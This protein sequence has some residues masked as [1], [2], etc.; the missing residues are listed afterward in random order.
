MLVRDGAILLLTQAE[1]DH[2]DLERQVLPVSGGRSV[3]KEG[4]LGTG[5]ANERRV[6][7]ETYE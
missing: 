3:S 2:L 1:L 6:D 4:A 7:G 5:E